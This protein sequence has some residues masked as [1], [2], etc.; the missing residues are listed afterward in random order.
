MKTDYSD[1]KFKNR[2]GF[3]DGEGVYIVPVN[4]G[5]A[6]E[7]G[8][9]VL[10]FH[11]A[12]K[13]KKIDL[14][15]KQPRVGFEMDC[16]HKLLENEEACEYSFCYESVIGQGNI[17][18]VEELEEKKAALKSIMLQYSG[19]DNWEFPEAVVKRTA[20]LRL[21]VTELTCKARPQSIPF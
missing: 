17:R 11:G 9:R 8:K 4:F 18:L 10:Y 13:G 6:W 21:E 16:R 15:A 20:V 3:Q 2:L 14:A 1:I 19:R 7:D 5:F 12:A